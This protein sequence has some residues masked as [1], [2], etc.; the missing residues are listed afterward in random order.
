MEQ[1]VNFLT[2]NKIPI[3]AWGKQF[4]TFLRASS[5]VYAGIWN[6]RSAPTR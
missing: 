1:I 6:W 4:F 3:G 5:R 2:G